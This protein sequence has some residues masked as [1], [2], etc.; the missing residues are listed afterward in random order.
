MAAGQYLSL[1]ASSAGLTPASSASS[2][3][4]GSWVEASSSLSTGIIVY[5]IEFAIP[6][7]PAAADTTYEQLFE[8]GTG[9][10]GAETTKIQ[11][12]FSYRADTITSASNGLGYW[13]PRVFRAYLPEPVVINLGTRVAVRAT[14]SIASAITYRGVKILY[15]ESTPPTVVLNSPSD[16]GT[17]TDTTPDLT[18]TGTD[19]DKNDIRYN[20]Q[21][22]TVNTFDSQGASI[23]TD[24]TN[25]NVATGF[26]TGPRTVNVSLTI[27]S[28]VTKLVALVYIWQDVAGTGTVSAI[29]WN[30]SE[31]LTLISS[32]RQTGTTMYVAA[33]YLDSPT[34]G[35]HTLATT[36]TGATDCI[37]VS[38]IPLFN[39]VSGYDQI[40][41]SGGNGTSASTSITPSKDNCIIVDAL[42]SFGGTTA[43]EGSTSFYEDT[44]G[45]INAASQYYIQ[46]T[47]AS[48]AMTWSWTT[49]GDYSHLVISFKST[50][51]PLLDKI[52]GTDAGF[53][54]SPDNTDPFTSGQLVTYTVQSALTDVTTYYWRVA[55]IDPNGSNTYGAW[56]TTQSFTVNTSPPATNHN[57]LTLLGVG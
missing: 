51:A 57:G 35:A 21:V 34:S 27:A 25:G 18:F 42:E 41:T 39:T 20:I 37:K 16:G 6:T 32:Y 33:Y 43:V 28:G 3:A 38:A 40:A 4:F 1:P 54:G 11:I 48:K 5:G 7:S 53:S 22:D 15:R 49:A 29:N 50:K 17:T 12:P 56:A 45:S 8:I 52:S 13:M 36:V 26:N 14:D 47:K 2:W 46:T 55:G 23:T 10:G 9:S 30:T 24:T 31:N 19:I 44:T